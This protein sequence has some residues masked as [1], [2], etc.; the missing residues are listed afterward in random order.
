MRRITSSLCGPVGVEA[1]DV[2]E[3]DQ[4]VGPQGDRERRRGGVGVDVVDVAV[5]AARDRRHDGHE[6][7]VEE[8]RHEVGPHVDHVAD[9]S[10]VDRLAVDEDVAALGGEQVGV[11]AGEADGVRPMGVEQPDDL[12]LH[13]PGQHHAH[14]VHGLRARDAVAAAELARDA[15]PVEHRR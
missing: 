4:L 10:D 7:V 8:L 15:Q 9:Q 1:L 14:D 3:H 6:A 2:G 11:L 12:A 5:L 13:L